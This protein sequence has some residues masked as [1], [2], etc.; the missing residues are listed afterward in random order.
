M[1]APISK[2]DIQD[3]IYIMALVLKY[4]DIIRPCNFKYGLGWITDNAYSGLASESLFCLT[5]PLKHID[6][7]IIGYR[8]SSIWSLQ[9][10]SLEET[11]CCHIGSKGSFICTFPQI[12]RSYGHRLKVLLEIWCYKTSYTITF[13]LTIK[14]VVAYFPDPMSTYQTR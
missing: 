9:H 7:H 2:L 12:F 5:T 11:H 13:V 14:Q 6:F 10:I 1:C 8:T 3:Q 4:V